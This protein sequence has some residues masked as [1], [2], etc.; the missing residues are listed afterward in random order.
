MSP[1]EYRTAIEELGLSVNGAA[2]F[3]GVTLRTSQRWAAG[4]IEIP[5]P[6]YLILA[7]MLAFGLTPGRVNKRLGRN[8]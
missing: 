7:L 4:D 6:V 3:L 2:H 8:P 5:F 1:S